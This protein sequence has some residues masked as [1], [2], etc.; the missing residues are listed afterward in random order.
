VPLLGDFDGDGRA[1]VTVWRPTTG[2]WFS[3]TSA[4]GLREA[5]VRTWGSGSVGDVPMVK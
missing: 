5:V 2:Q 3:L 4:S 1:D